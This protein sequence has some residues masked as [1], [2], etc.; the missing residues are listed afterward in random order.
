MSSEMALAYRKEGKKKR[1]HYA[2]LLHIK[3]GY[4]CD[5]AVNK[6]DTREVI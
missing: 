2:T 5:K 6:N 1:S 4:Q 3:C